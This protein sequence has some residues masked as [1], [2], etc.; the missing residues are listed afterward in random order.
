[1]TSRDAWFEKRDAIAGS[2]EPKNQPGVF[3]KEKSIGRGGLGC[4]SL[5][6]GV[7]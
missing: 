6:K 4:D 7:W 1:M 2:R 5:Y 3:A